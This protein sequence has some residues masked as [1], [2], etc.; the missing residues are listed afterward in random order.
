MAKD[1]T[2]RGGKRPGAGRKPKSLAQKIA[3]GQIS[4]EKVHP[5]D[6]PI[7]ND[8]PTQPIPKPDSYLSA[9]Q[10]MDDQKFKA[11]DIYRETMR[12][13]YDRGCGHLVNHRLVET[14]AD[15]FARFIQCSEAVSEYG[16]IGKHPTTGSAIPS[17]FTQLEQQYQKQA[18]VIW[19]EIFEIIKTN[20]LKPYEGLQIDPMEALLAK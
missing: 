13:I 3:D 16:F 20:C 12:W 7:G 8:I 2:K 10:A 1:G 14:Y 4:L 17:P 18:F 11:A 19:S 6:I 9:K 5:L 15:M